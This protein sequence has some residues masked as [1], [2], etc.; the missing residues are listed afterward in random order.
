MVISIVALL[1]SVILGNLQ[2]GR[3]KTVNAKNNEVA[4]Q[5]LTA[6]Y[7][8]N[9]SNGFRYPLPTATGEFCLGNYTDNTCGYVPGGPTVGE[10]V[11]LQNAL[12]PYFPQLPTG[13]SIKTTISGS[14]V[15]LRGPT[16]LCSDTAISCPIT[17]MKW[18]IYDTG[19][20]CAKGGSRVSINGS[21]P[22][23]AM[24]ILTVF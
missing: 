3:I 21:S 5:Y 10:S 11:T 8:A 15:E 1:S 9:T 4:N 12:L 16:Y 19:I 13:E 7:F 17:A 23:A 14:S 20:P 24:C 2:V 6:L 18:Y 22:P